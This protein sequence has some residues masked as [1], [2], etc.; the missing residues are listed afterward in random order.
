MTLF[1]LC[2]RLLVRCPVSSMVARAVAYY[3]KQEYTAFLCQFHFFKIK[4]AVSEWLGV[5][6][7]KC[8]IIANATSG[9]GGGDLS[10]RLQSVLIV[11]LTTTRRGSI[12]I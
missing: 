7:C 3:K 1:L 11:I 2:V 9:G 8:I 5:V 12:N 10:S 4:C 6:L